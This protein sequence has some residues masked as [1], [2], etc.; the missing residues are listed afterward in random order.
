MVPCVVGY[1]YIIIFTVGIPSLDLWTFYSCAS[2]IVF[3]RH[4]FEIEKLK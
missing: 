4:L 1:V 2:A 3:P